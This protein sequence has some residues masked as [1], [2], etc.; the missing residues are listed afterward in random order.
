MRAMD[1][2]FNTAGALGYL[3][4]LVRSIN[5]AKDTGVSG[6]IVAEGQRLLHP[7]V[8]SERR[9]RAQ[10]DMPCATYGTIVTAGNSY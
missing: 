7:A 8:Y 10:N 9:R 6:G 2:D 4:E 5:Q 3:F 1:D